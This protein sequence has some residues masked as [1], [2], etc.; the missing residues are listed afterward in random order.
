MTCS[1]IPLHFREDLGRPFPHSQPAPRSLMAKIY[2]LNFLYP[3]RSTRRMQGVSSQLSQWRRRPG[4][5][6]TGPRPV[7]S[8]LALIMR[9]V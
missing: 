8:I 4:F 6:D 5:K 2:R 1:K 9:S 7:F 3:G